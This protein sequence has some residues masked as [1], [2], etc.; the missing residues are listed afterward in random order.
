[1]W[2]QW[3]D[4][5]EAN[6]GECMILNATGHTCPGCGIQSAFIA[7]CRGDI[8][9]SI[10]LYPALIPLLLMLVFLVVHLRYK[11]SK[12]GII[13]KYGMIG[14]VVLILGNYFWHF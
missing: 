11:F 8:L 13:L 1:M 14:I 9:T 2:S 6:L 4:Q 12:G 7:L 5:L 3:I 10:Q